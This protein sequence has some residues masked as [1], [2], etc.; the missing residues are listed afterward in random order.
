MC[1]KESISLTMTFDSRKLYHCKFVL[2]SEIKLAN[3]THGELNFT[4]S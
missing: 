2:I 3:L 4:L 1:K